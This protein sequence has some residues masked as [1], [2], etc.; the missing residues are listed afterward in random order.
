MQKRGA[1]APHHEEFHQT[2]D[3]ALVPGSAEV[4]DVLGEGEPGADESTVDEAIEWAFEVASSGKN[5]DQEENGLHRFFEDRSLDDR[6]DK[7]GHALEPGEDERYL[8]GDGEDKGEDNRGDGTPEETDAQKELRLRS[9]AIEPEHI[10]DDADQRDGRE[11]DEC[12]QSDT[13]AQSTKHGED[14][15]SEDEPHENEDR[16]N[17]PDDVARR[18]RFGLRLCFPYGSGPGSVGDDLLGRLHACADP[19]LLRHRRRKP[20]LGV[21]TSLHRRRIHHRLTGHG[22]ALHHR[23]ALRLHWL[24]G[25]RP[26]LLW[27]SLHDRLTLR[28]HRLT[29]RRHRLALRRHGSTGRQLRILSRH[30]RLL[31]L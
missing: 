8:A 28:R 11:S 27:L 15:Q 24:A 23:L 9:P 14:Y 5:D 29:L 3:L 17:K 22:L 19:H 6:S 25:C 1:Q 16:G 7:A 18:F 2:L 12:E 13:E 26:H 4:E 30:R 31:G 10:G 21:D 20:R